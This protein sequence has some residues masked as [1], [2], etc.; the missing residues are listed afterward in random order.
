VPEFE[1]RY[2]DTS[3][4][5]LIVHPE[6]AYPD[7]NVIMTSRTLVTTEYVDEKVTEALGDIEAA[8]AAL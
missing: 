7:G 3:S 1:L 5:K 4:S 2:N 6:S 8:L